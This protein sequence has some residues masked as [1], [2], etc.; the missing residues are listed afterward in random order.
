MK[1]VLFCFLACLTVFASSYA[2]YKKTKFFTKNGRIYE[3]GMVKRIF[4]GERSS[5]YGIVAGMG[6]EK[7]EMRSNHWFE[8][9]LI[10]GTPFKYSRQE[11]NNPSRLVTISGTGGIT[12]GFRYN[13]GYFLVA[14][15]EKRKLL[16]LLQIGLGWCGNLSDLKNYKITPD[17]AIQ[18]LPVAG[19]ISNFT[20]S[21]GAGLIYRVTERLGLRAS[22]YYHGVLSS[23]EK[24][25]FNPVIS[26]PSVNL[27]LRIRVGSEN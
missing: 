3:V 9:E 20:L 2:Q 15:T 25:F 19:N 22:G 26:H 8:A 12:L 10:A 6:R 16:P 7:E 1:K 27:S 5:S 17:E 23:E 4:S 14:N 24:G 21:G 11:Y 13:Y 18:S